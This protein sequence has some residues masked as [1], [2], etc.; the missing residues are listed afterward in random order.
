MTG[1][2]ISWLSQCAKDLSLPQFREL[3]FS[4]W[5]VWKERNDRVWNQ[6]RLE[7]WDVS[8]G[9]VSRLKEFRFHNQKPP[10]SKSVYR[11]VWRTPPVGLVKI[12]VDGAFHHVTRKGGLGFVIRNETGVMLGGGAWSVSGLLSSEHAEILA[13][14]AA[15]EFAGEHGFG[16]AILE[17]DAFEVQHQLSR[18]ASANLSLLGRIY[19]DV[20]I[21]LKSHSVVQVLHVSR[22]G[23]G[24]AHVLATYGHSLRQNAFYFSVPDFL[25]VVIAAELCTL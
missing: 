14:K 17:I 5:G 8:L 19:D 13:C 1:D 4:L 18:C 11:A 3:L 23:N 7:A 2:V 12:N 20:G 10:R 6:K 24:I 21:L 9:I 15:L 25:Q 22:Q 16:P